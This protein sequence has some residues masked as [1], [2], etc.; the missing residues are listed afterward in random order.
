MPAWIGTSL[1]KLIILS[2][3]S[4]NFNRN[5]PIQP[6]HL[7]DLQLLD[8]PSNNL[9]SKIPKYLGNITAMKEIGSENVGI[10]DPYINYIGCPGVPLDFYNDKLVLVWKGAISE[11]KYLGLLKNI[12]LSSNKLIGVS[13]KLWD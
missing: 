4:N 11:F 3:R 2:L 12:D 5:L 6:C 9:S 7:A 8:L 1:T 13:L 10:E